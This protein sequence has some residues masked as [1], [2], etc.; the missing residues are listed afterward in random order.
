LVLAA[1]AVPASRF[2]GI[3]AILDAMPE[4]AHNYRRDHRLNM[5]FVLATK[6]PQAIRASLAAIEEAARLTVYAFP[7]EREYFLGLWFELGAD[8]ALRT[9]SPVLPKPG[10]QWELDELAQRIVAS[11]QA[12]LPLTPEPCETL[13]EAL[14]CS[15]AEV[16]LRMEAMLRSGAIRRIGLV[17]N[18]YKLGFGGN[19]M[20]VW[21]VPNHRLDRVGERIGALDCVSHCYARPRHPPDWPYNLFAMVH[22]RDRREVLRRVAEISKLLDG[23]V[24]GHDVLFSTEILKKTG[25]RL[26]GGARSRD[27]AGKAV[28]AVHRRY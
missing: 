14:G 2:D 5:W 19:G 12:G 4:V 17:P 3:A 13:A 28:T 23:Q 25:M 22:G 20:T 15:T 21:S 8:G 7:K 27:A 11:T 26:T 6:T 16:V 24:Q 1:M 10:P 18:H 9:R